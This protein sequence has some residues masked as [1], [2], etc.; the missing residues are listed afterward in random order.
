MKRLQLISSNSGTL[1]RFNPA[2]FLA[3]VYG[4]LRHFTT[5]HELSRTFTTTFDVLLFQIPVRS[6]IYD[7][8][9]KLRKKILLNYP[10]FFLDSTKKI[11]LSNC[12]ENVT[13]IISWKLN[14]ILNYLH[15]VPSFL[16]LIK[17]RI[18][19][20]N[21]GS[22][23]VLFPNAKHTLFTFLWAS[24]DCLWTRLSAWVTQ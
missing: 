8:S 17:V 20:L 11:F 5:F 13:N 14:F 24:Y 12:K 1:I 9:S 22:S 18:C 10:R 15:V 19:F 7:E 21:L 6:G 2:R 3:T 16:S 23:E 4:L